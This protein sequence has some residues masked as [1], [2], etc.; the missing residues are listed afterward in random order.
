MRLPRLH[1]KIYNEPWFITP[2]GYRAVKAVFEA[3]VV[4]SNCKQGDYEEDNESPVSLLVNPR[5]P[6][7]IDPNG[8]ASIDICGTLGK[9]LS[10]LEKCCGATDYE[11]IED[12]IEAAVKANVR[13]IFFEIDSPG[14]QCT[15]N[16]EVADLIQSLRGRIP[17]VAYTDDMACSAA[18]NIAVSCDYIF[19]SQSATVGSIGTII[20]F[21]DE[22]EMWAGEGLKFDPVT[23]AEGDLKATMMGPS[24]GSAAQRAYLQQYVQDAFE[25]FKGNVLR[26]RRVPEEAMRGQAFMAPRALTMNLI[27]GILTEESAYNKLLSLV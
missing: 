10:K 20:P 19:A 14:G 25:Q 24:I 6:M 4:R 21:V 1:Q 16:S 11:D 7:E 5:E 22:S 26:N 27:D 12:E 15:G 8:I 9:G 13:G 3:K 18:Y 17:M 23:N 2:A